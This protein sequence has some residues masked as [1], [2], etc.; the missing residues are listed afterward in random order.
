MTILCHLAK[1]GFVASYPQ[2]NR[3]V[4]ANLRCDLTTILSTVSKT[5]SVGQ[6]PLLVLE[7]VEVS[8]I[9]SY[10]ETLPLNSTKNKEE[11]ENDNVPK[12]QYRQ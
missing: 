1:W 6:Q 7:Q 3:Y 10:Y 9:V 5:T 12:I 8:N 11:N 2:S 4:R